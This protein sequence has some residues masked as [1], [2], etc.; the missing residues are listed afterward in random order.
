MEKE[1]R[2]KIKIRRAYRLLP[3]FFG[4]VIAAMTVAA[5]LLHPAGEKAVSAPAN[6]AVPSAIATAVPQPSAAPS[7][8]PAA[9]YPA[10]AVEVVADGNALFTLSSE[11]E[12]VA[13]IEKYLSAV[14]TESLGEYTAVLSVAPAVPLLVQSPS[15][16][17]PF[18]DSGAALSYLL[19][20]PAALPA[21]SAVQTVEITETDLDDR[22]YTSDLLAAGD[23]IIRALERPSYA[24]QITEESYI[25]GVS[26]GTAAEQSFLIGSTATGR[27]TEVGT[28]TGAEDGSAP[29]L[30]DWPAGR[31][32]EGLR[33]LTPVKGTVCGCFGLTGETMHYSLDYKSEEGFAVYAPESGTVIYCGERKNMG[34][35]IEIEHGDSGFVSRL[36]GADGGDFIKL[37]DT[38]K[39]GAYIASV[40]PGTAKQKPVLRYELL[41]NSTPVNPAWYLK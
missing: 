12:A 15:G 38:V 17:S 14:Y 33:F 37:G 20:N 31:E 24:L 5:L 18:M 23:C 40:A 34:R 41:Y 39:R 36:I 25:G 27:I 35:V 3:L 6:T 29:K 11:E 28:R 8:T 13:V 26:A 9:D 22:Y 1:S 2:K 4:A 32:A 19:E 10:G 16:A 30:K 7:P 21:V